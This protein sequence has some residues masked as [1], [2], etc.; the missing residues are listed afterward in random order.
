M[1]RA[2]TG[3]FYTHLFQ[4]HSI[5]QQ[6]QRTGRNI[7][8]CQEGQSVYVGGEVKRVIPTWHS[9]TAEG[10][11]AHDGRLASQTSV[12]VGQDCEERRMRSST[13]VLSITPLRCLDRPLE[14]G[15]VGQG[16]L[17]ARRSGEPGPD[18]SSLLDAY[19]ESSRS[20]RSIGGRCVWPFA[21]NFGLGIVIA[22]D[23]SRIVLPWSSVSG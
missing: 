9:T 16:R 3:N 8:A 6:C 1:V 10:S 4:L 23:L 22:S 19:P 13:T 20:R 5:L 2:I 17:C 11:C 12:A 14:P 18:F 7:P 15:G 21:P